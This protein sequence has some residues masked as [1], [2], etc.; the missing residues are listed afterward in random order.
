VRKS[1]VQSTCQNPIGPRVPGYP[2]P[3]PAQPG[4]ATPWFTEYLPQPA[5]R[6]RPV[7]GADLEGD[8][9]DHRRN[10]QSGRA[11]PIDIDVDVVAAVASEHLVGWAKDKGLCVKVGESLGA[12]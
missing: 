4:P 1:S 6:D 5:L 12:Q 2:Q 11:A 3:T 10:S 8:R 7:T 9:Q